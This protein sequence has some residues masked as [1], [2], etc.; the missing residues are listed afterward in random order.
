MAPEEL[1][2]DHMVTTV[3]VH[4]LGVVLTS[5][6]PFQHML[7]RRGAL[8]KVDGDFV[9]A[10][11]SDLS[12]LLFNA[13]AGAE[14]AM[15]PYTCVCGEMYMV[16]ECGNVVQAGKCPKCQRPIRQ[17]EGGNYNE[18]AKNDTRGEKAGEQACAC[19]SAGVADW[20]AGRIARIAPDVD[21]H[22]MCSV[23]DTAGKRVTVKPVAAQVL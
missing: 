15:T 11:P 23:Q 13:V 3:L 21:M 7:T 9:M 1:T 6:N 22:T 14:G 4:F 19:L 10:M 8:S 2:K 16:G 5:D 18:R 12:S 17:K 20:N